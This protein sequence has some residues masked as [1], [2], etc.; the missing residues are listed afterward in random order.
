M[1]SR[2]L[3]RHLLWVYNTATERVIIPEKILRCLGVTLTQR[4][5][6]SMNLECS[7]WFLLLRL[8]VAFSS[9]SWSKHKVDE[10]LTCFS[11]RDVKSRSFIWR[12]QRF[13]GVDSSHSSGRHS[14]GANCRYI[15]CWCCFSQEHLSF[16]SSFSGASP[17]LWPGQWMRKDG[18]CTILPSH[19][20]HH[21]YKAGH[22]MRNCNPIACFAHQALLAWKM[23]VIRRLR[24]RLK[25][26]C[27]TF[28]FPLL[29]CPWQS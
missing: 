20:S 13:G 11:K 1:W 7:R 5:M 28:T 12:Q 19:L 24:L 22:I 6:L 25:A 9:E 2:M 10:F 18:T 15:C 23:Q 8:T 29:L 14:P 21:L 3:K 26:G 16:P 27:E 4:T 17:E